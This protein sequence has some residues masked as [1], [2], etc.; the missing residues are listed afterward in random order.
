MI[1]SHLSGENDYQTVKQTILDGC[2][3]TIEGHRQKFRQHE[4]AQEKLRLFK[5]WLEAAAITDLDKLI[6]LIVT[7]EFM[8]KLPQNIIADKEELELK[9]VSMLANNYDLI[10]KTVKGTERPVK[11]D[12]A[13]KG[14]EE[15][16]SL[17]YCSYFKKTNH[18]ISE[19]RAL[20]CKRS[21]FNGKTGVP[22]TGIKDPGLNKQSIKDNEALLC[23]NDSNEDLFADY[24]RKG[25]VT[26]Y[27]DE[28]WGEGLDIK[29]HRFCK[30][31]DSA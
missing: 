22:E 26:F 15:K 13:T 31:H 28:P 24:L 29:R 21:R 1:V 17:L 11:Q 16:E 8:R 18:D 7:E 2:A 4:F 27:D 9:K 25:T 10:H 19:C 30:K 12:K 23:N 3:I 14:T 5:N 20:G 6:N